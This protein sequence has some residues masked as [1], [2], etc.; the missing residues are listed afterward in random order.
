MPIR[1]ELMARRNRILR[2]RSV[3]SSKEAKF[4]AT[5][6]IVKKNVFDT[7][8]PWVK[9]RMAGVQKY[10]QQPVVGKT[11]LELGGGHGLCGNEFHKL[12]AIVTT[13]DALEEHIDVAKQRYPHLNAFQLDV[14]HDSLP[15]THYDIILHWGL[16]YHIAEI[17]KHLAD[18]CHAC[19]TLLLESEV[20][21]SENPDS[22]FRR[23]EQGAD[24]AANNVGM[25]PSAA[26]IEVILKKNGFD[27]LR[28]V[29]PILNGGQHIY[30][31]K[32]KETGEWTQSHRRFWIAWRHT[33]D[34]N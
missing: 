8:G 31:W 12:G 16:L 13:C 32:C 29:D 14:E 3:T 25:R 7:Y 18:V 11:L 27:F 19:D 28:I 1:Q 33:H 23:T 2:N 4:V 30:D 15:D 5:S 6:P 10:L 24:Q 17:D 34:S 20:I 9:S 22:F 21:D 26:M